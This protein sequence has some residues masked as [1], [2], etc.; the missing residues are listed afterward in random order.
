MLVSS[1]CERLKD[2]S[3][4]FAWVVKEEEEEEEKESSK[5][6]KI[7]KATKK[8][9]AVLDQGIP[10]EIKAHYHVLQQASLCCLN[11]SFLSLS[12]WKIFFCLLY[13]LLQYTFTE[14]KN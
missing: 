10:D 5:E 11:S 6:E 13:S 7:V 12:F 8:G 9:V 1:I 14:H 3:L 4:F 2:V